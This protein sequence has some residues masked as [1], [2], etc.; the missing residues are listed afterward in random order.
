MT[1]TTIVKK[2]LTFQQKKFGLLDSA[3]NFVSLA[4]LSECRNLADEKLFWQNVSWPDSEFT[5]IDLGDLPCRLTGSS[6]TL[7]L[8]KI[9]KC[10]AEDALVKIRIPHPRHD[11]FLTDLG[12]VRAILPETLTELDPRFSKTGLATQLAVRFETIS[13]AMGLDPQWQKSVDAGEI[14]YADI[15]VISKQAANVIQWMDIELQIKK[16]MWIQTAASPL[17]DDMRKQLTDQLQSHLT[18]GDQQAAATIQKFLDSSDSLNKIEIK[19]QK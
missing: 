2:T 17:T 14:T 1:A 16:S 19:D 9:W 5:A 6:L 12:Y 4:G 15:E 18:R 3:E 8:Q 10:S 11:L 7:A 13:V